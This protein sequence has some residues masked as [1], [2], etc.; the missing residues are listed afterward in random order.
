MGNVECFSVESRC[1]RA[2]SLERRPIARN[3]QTISNKTDENKR[4]R[5]EKRWR[6][7]PRKWRRGGVFE[8]LRFNCLRNPF[9]V[10]ADAGNTVTVFD[11][12][13]PE[14]RLAD[15]EFSTIL[16]IIIQYYP[17]RFNYC[18]CF[19][20]HFPESREDPRARK[21]LVFLFL[22]RIINESQRWTQVDENRH[23]LIEFN[24]LR[25]KVMSEQRKYPTR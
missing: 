16:S 18:F 5:A 8:K 25:L 23:L 13:P 4:L 12:A 7:S 9:G 11:D 6:R 22:L 2:K 1:C 19:K 3:Y 20:K 24:C 10:S 21:R 14:E 17:S 15:I